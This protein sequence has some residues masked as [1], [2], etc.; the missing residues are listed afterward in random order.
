MP[1]FMLEQN[2]NQ[3]PDTPFTPETPGLLA[4]AQSYSYYLH[5]KKYF[6]LITGLLVVLILLIA[7]CGEKQPDGNNPGGRGKSGK[8][9]SQ[10]SA[11]IPV[12]VE[13]ATRGEISTFLMQTTTIEAER[14][15]DVLAKVSGQVIK[16]P[17]E[18]GVR[19]KKGDLMAE[20]NEAE[21]KIDFIKTQISMETEKST[22]D[23]AQKM[24]EKK[25]IAEENFETIRLQYESSKATHEAARIQLDYTSIRSPFN[26]VVTARNIELGQRVNAN[27]VLFRIADF[28][29]LRAKIYVPEKDM[30]RIFEGQAAKINVEAQTELEFSGY[31]KMVSP[32][33]DPESGTAK[34]T[35][36]IK[37]HRG[38]LKPGMFA[39]VFITT[40]THRNTLIIPKK[41]L[42]LESDVD[43]VYIYQDGKAH[44]VTLKLDIASG[45]KVEV[46]AG[47]N[48]GALVVVAGQEGLREGLP[49]RIPGQEV[50]T[51][52]D[53]TGR[54]STIVNKS[55]N[56]DS[57]F[58]KKK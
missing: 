33:V 23:R 25:L 51:H 32:I 8:K 15:V 7:G 47:L 36:D 45:D 24:L 55:K 48:E 52:D 18:E 46:V 6:S 17:A 35:I 14:Q 12:Q 10:N 42:I 56:Q 27:Q 50:V 9:N 41:A 49:I 37:N 44:K 38:K 34:V 19:L 13:A 53:S 39:S 28:N 26:G 1:E 22:L 11:A 29:P 2:E 16:L 43:Q 5:L 4:L 57:S 54:H 3:M 21:L 30:W 40:E 31:V 20:L 58:N